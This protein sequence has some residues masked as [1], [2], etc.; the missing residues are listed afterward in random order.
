MIASLV[1]AWSQ[2]D[3]RF[4]LLVA[5]GS[6]A[7]MRVWSAFDFIPKALAFERAEPATIEVSA[8]RRWSTRSSGRLPL[9][10][11]ACAAMLSALVAS[12]RLA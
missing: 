5:F 8:A 2:G 6:H 7:A 11:V 1:V 9:D 10:L 4:A 3:V 12:A